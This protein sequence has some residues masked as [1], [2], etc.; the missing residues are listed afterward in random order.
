MRVQS[1]PCRPA[2]RGFNRARMYL[3]HSISICC[4]VR[5]VIWACVG[6]FSLAVSALAQEPEDASRM[7]MFPP[8]L[9]V[10]GTFYLPKATYSSHR[11]FGLGVNAYR[12]FRLS[13]SDASVA[14]SEVE[15]RIAATFKGQE[16][17]ELSTTLRMGR[18]P[19]ELKILTAYRD[20]TEEFFGIGPDTPRE[21]KEV[22]KPEN[23]RAY[24]ELSRPIGYGISLGVRAEVE[25]Q[26]LEEVAKEGA[27]IGSGIR[28]TERSRVV[29][30]GITAEWDRTVRTDTTLAGWRASS[31]YIF[32]D[33]KMGGD[34]TFDNYHVDLRGYV[35]L[36]RRQGL[37]A[38]LFFYS[39]RGEPPFWRY[40]AMGGREHTRGYRKGRFLDRTLVAFQ[41][42]HRAWLW[43]RVGVVGF[44]GLG[45][46]AA[47]LRTMELEHMKPNVGGGL[48]ARLGSSQKATARFDVGF[49]ER[50]PRFYLGFG[51]AF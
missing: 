49:G 5:C 18:A 23:V 37:A 44:A 17:L 30:S 50:E 51:E 4:V 29:G 15:A 41:L 43:W 16:K 6:S 9:Y 45:D 24:A 2:Q 36:P 19:Y 27:L 22:Y 25:G 10:G 35:P 39:V 26:H 33:E 1:W 28:G 21:A 38:Q 11:G 8:R 20:M 3:S 12:P 13:G 31:F 40:A 7:R 47:N 42:E 14:A 46:V 34:Y 48:R 32:F